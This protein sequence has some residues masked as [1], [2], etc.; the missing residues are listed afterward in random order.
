MR[1][2][3]VYYRVAPVDATRARAAALAMQALLQAQH[4][5]LRARLLRQPGE[6]DGPQTWMEAYST[7]AQAAP[8]G[9]D[10]DLQESIE[11]AARVLAP[12]ISGQ[13]HIEVFIACAS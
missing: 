13:R 1:E 3:F 12:L 7:D 5:H 10:T 8:A 4:P 11:A 9:V 6:A 2:L